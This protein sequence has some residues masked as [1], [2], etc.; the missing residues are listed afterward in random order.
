MGDSEY[1]P[2]IARNR[3]HDAEF[4]E[5]WRKKLRDE[6]LERMIEA[7]N[8]ETARE[9]KRNRPIKVKTFSIE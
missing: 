3:K 4:R 7:I 6:E 8:A 2:M 5:R 1:E 9:E